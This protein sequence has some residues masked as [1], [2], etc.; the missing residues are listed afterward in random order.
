[1]SFGDKPAGVF[2]DIVLRKV[3]V[4]FKHID[5]SAAEKLNRDRYVDDVATGGRGGYRKINALV[6]KICRPPWLGDG[7]NFSNYKPSN[8]LESNSCTTTINKLLPSF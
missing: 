2:L 6:K 4:M 3:A 5:P 7:E 8:A 1:M